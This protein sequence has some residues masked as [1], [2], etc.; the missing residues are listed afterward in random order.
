[1]LYEVITVI[2]GSGY[3]ANEIIRR[4][5]ALQYCFGKRCRTCTEA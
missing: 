3:G 1:M 4:L 5:G 2:G